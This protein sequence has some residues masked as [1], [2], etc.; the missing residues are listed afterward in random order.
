MSDLLL[1]PLLPFSA[2]PF[3]LAPLLASEGPRGVVRLLA[4]TRGTGFF[5]APSCTLALVVCLRGVAVALWHRTM[6]AHTPTPEEH[7]SIESSWRR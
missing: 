3:M 1:L 7:K 5:T 2:C 4:G 6:S